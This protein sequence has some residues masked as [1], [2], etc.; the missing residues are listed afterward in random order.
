MQV[1]RYLIRFILKIFVEIYDEDFD[2]WL[3]ESLRIDYIFYLIEFYLFYFDDTLE[4]LIDFR[5]LK[6][7]INFLP[8]FYA[9]FLQKKTHMHKRLKER[10][11]KYQST[12]EVKTIH[13]II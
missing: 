13:H 8:T 4:L 6:V 10:H 9:F 2:I 1:Q 5:H 7:E 3:D 11:I 12:S